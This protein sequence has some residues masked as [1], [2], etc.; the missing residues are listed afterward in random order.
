MDSACSSQYLAM[1][2]SLA[3][4]PPGLCVVHRTVSEP[5][6]CGL[7]NSLLQQYLV[8]CP[9][10]SHFGVVVLRFTS[11]SDYLVEVLLH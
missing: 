9:Y 5:A 11:D 6:V 10:R 8:Q 1:N 7:V 4:S 2:V 3:E